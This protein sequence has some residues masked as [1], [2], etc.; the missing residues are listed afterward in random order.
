MPESPDTHT[1]PTNLGSDD[2]KHWIQFRSFKFGNKSE[3]NLDVALYI[4][5]DALNTNYKSEYDS[6]EVG[7]MG[8]SFI[9]QS[10]VAGGGLDVIDLF[11]QAG[12]ALW[13]KLSSGE[14]LA[15]KGIS[16]ISGGAADEALGRATGK[17]LNPYLVSAYKGPTGMRD[18]TF[19][20]KMFPRNKIDS[21]KI[22][23]ISRAFKKAMLPS[24]EGGVSQNTPMGMFGYP[25]EFVIQFFINGKELPK[26][27]DSPLFQIG[28]S[29]LTDIAL[30]YTTQDTVLF[31]ENTQN[32]VSIEM[33][34]SFTEINVLYR[35]LVSGEQ[36]NY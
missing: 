16:T 11:A 8:A 32:P 9:N 1:W 21:Q 14:E 30:D 2:L 26:G 33:K 34:L 27:E 6:A 5:P 7:R 24:H 29:V 15:R 17:I 10:A 36:G 31:F 20:F 28:R 35:E 23:R 25:D 18:H 13:S 3:P 4:P 12:S 22:T 19:T